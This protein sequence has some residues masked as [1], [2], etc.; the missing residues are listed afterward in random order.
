VPTGSASR[1]LRLSDPRAVGLSFAQCR[2]QQKTLVH[3][4]L[5][6]GSIFMLVTFAGRQLAFLSGEPSSQPDPAFNIIYIIILSYHDPSPSSDRL[7]SIMARLRD[8]QRGCEWDRRRLSPPSRRIRSRKPTKSPMRSN[9]TT[10][11]TFAG[12]TWRPAAP[13][14][15]P[16]PHGRGSRTLRF[17]DVAA[18][19]CDKMEARHPH[20]FG[21]EGRIHDARRWEA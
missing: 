16:C 13:G 12:R 20:I 8:P 6:W 11:R 10:W 7:L 9:A 19:I 2:G 4:G 3:A 17:D 14:R 18:A 15:V 5:A 21:D 1:S